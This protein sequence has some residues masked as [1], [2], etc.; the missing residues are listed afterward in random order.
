MLYRCILLVTFIFFS[1]TSFSASFDCKKA[2]TTTEKL[3]C[4]DK[5]LNFL[6]EELGVTYKSLLLTYSDPIRTEIVTLQKKWLKQRNKECLNRK[7]CADLYKTQ[8][9]ELRIK[10]QKGVNL[11]S[12]TI[13]RQSCRASKDQE[14][15]IKCVNLKSYD[16][17]D[18]SGGK[19]GRAQCG[20]IHAE[21]ANRK[22]QTL[23]NNI[24]EAINRN[25]EKSKEIKVFEESVSAWENYRESHCTFTNTVN[26]LDNF[27]GN[28]LSIAYCKRRLNEQRALELEKILSKSW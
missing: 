18:D 5:Y 19:W 12:F 26:F 7:T 24:K 1:S 23:N 4:S 10:L 25:G 13:D 11:S 27:N 15:L 28:N 17:C 16:P 8:T 6:D 2:S 22:A 21:I 3:I 14:V 9:K 20:W